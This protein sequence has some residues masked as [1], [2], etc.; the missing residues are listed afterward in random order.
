MKRKFTGSTTIA[1]ALFVTSGVLA[2]ALGIRHIDRL[3]TTT[4][5][6]LTQNL[7]AG[8]VITP[9]TLVRQKT[10]QQGIDQSIQNPQLLL[11]K[12]INVAKQ[13][14]EAIYA[15]E[16]ATPKVKSL[17]Y[18]VPEGRVL[19]T[20]SQPPSGLPFSKLNQGDRFDIL[21]RG[22]TNVRTVARNVQLIGL[23]KPQ[24]KSIANSGSK[25]ESLN[26]TNTKATTGKTALVMAVRPADVYPLASIGVNDIVTIVLHSAYDIANGTQ[27]LLG[28]AKTHREVIIHSGNR[29]KTVSIAR[30]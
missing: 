16:L 18:A 4:A 17:S 20:L 25:I 11:G 21:V 10:E 9:A 26:A 1:I 22:R 8:D 5:L 23:L 12:T 6:V 2:S 13:S 19:F 7:Q 15:N 27:P 24:S 14:G 30:E 28:M 29:R 3:T